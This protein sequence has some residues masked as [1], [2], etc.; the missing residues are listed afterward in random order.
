M[1]LTVTDIAG[2]TGT[3]T[4]SVVVAN[5]VDVCSNMSGVQATVPVGMVALKG[6][7]IGTAASNIIAGTVGIDSIDGA[8]GND[9]ING[10]GGNDTLI[11]N[12]GNDTLNG[13]TGL[14]TLSGGAGNDI[15]NADDAAAGDK[16][17]CGLGVDTATI[18]KG[19]TTVG[20]EKVI[21]R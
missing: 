12:I 3:T 17:D 5:A 9:T 16:V 20:C 1:K 19:D 2:N 4:Q 15:I 18:N 11:G 8:G 7:C 14:D 10:N 13:G 21:T 6:A